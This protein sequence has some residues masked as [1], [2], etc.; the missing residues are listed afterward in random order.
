MSNQRTDKKNRVVEVIEYYV[1]HKE[2]PSGEALEDIAQR[3]DVSVYTIRDDIRKAKEGNLGE[4]VLDIIN[5]RL[6]SAVDDVESWKNSDLIKLYQATRPKKTEAKIDLK[7]EID[8]RGDAIG[9]ALKEL[10]GI[11]DRENLQ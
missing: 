2:F 11:R 8:I 7:A 1:E 9:E 10:S 6:E 4:R 3:H 5:T